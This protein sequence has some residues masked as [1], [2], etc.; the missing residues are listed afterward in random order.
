MPDQTLV[1]MTFKVNN[2]KIRREKRG[3]REVIIIPSATLPDNI[4]MNEILYP[5]A[6]IEAGYESIN[7]APAPYGHPV[8]DGKYISAQSPMG[9]NIGWIGAHNENARREG[10]RV[11]VDKVIDVEVA[12]STPRGKRVLEAIEN[13]K[14]IHTSTGIL[15]NLHD[16]LD[17]NGS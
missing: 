17:T 12:E 2:S 3:G 9:I 15:C 13:E 4:I 8:A 7:N 16:T 1:N 5:A 10:G 14:P 6:E 11:L